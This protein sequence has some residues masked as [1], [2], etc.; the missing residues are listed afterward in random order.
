MVVVVVFF[1]YNATFK[2]VIHLGFFLQKKIGS[3]DHISLKDIGGLRC[4][5]ILAYPGHSIAFSPLNWTKDMCSF[6]KSSLQL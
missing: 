4:L 3:D 1:S 2:H 5:T 6:Y